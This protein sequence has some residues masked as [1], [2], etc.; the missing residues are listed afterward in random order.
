MVGTDDRFASSGKENG[1]GQGESGLSEHNDGEGK[2]KEPDGEEA[3]C[4]EY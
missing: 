3:T 4:G 2:R 1:Q